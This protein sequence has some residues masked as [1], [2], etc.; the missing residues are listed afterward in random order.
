[1][2]IKILRGEV[3]KAVSQVNPRPFIGARKGFPL[4]KPS[5]VKSR[6]QP[7]FSDWMLQFSS[8]LDATQSNAGQDEVG[9]LQGTS[10]LAD[11]SLPTLSEA[12]HASSTKNVTSSDP[13]DGQRSMEQ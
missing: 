13:M 6:H 3:V 2:M 7:I 11:S 5:E 10:V 4:K 12:E 1:M 9:A 8:Q